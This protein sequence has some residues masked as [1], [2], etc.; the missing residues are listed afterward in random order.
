MLVC[1]IHVYA[2]CTT[3][4]HMHVFIMFMCVRDK[5]EKQQQHLPSVCSAPLSSFDLGRECGQVNK[6]TV[7]VAACLSSSGFLIQRV[8]MPHFEKLP[9]H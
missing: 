8:K 7:F 6:P 4:G 3:L 5:C 1:C 2:V 9:P